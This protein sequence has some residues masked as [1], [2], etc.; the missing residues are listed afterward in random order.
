M[1]Y[2]RHSMAA[3]AGRR[4]H[5]APAPAVGPQTRN[6]QTHAKQRGAGEGPVWSRCLPARTRPGRGWHK[7]A[8][9]LLRHHAHD[10]VSRSS[11]SRAPTETPSAPGRRRR[12]RLPLVPL[13]PPP[14]PAGTDDCALLAHRFHLHACCAES[15]S[16]RLASAATT[17]SVTGS[18]GPASSARTRSSCCALCSRQGSCRQGRHAAQPSHPPS[19]ASGRAAQQHLMQVCRCL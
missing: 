18:W 5:E 14:L 2:A 15:S 10:P 6:S 7:L 1:L 8:P 13:L 16:R 4:Q 19:G 17:T 9:A 12:R 11:G 3:A